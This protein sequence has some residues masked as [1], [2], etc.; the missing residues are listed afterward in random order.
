MNQFTVL[1]LLSVIGA[2]ALF[3]ALALFLFAITGTLEQIGGEE[4]GYGLQAS[5]LSKIRVGVRAIEVET[6]LIPTQV[7]LLNTTLTSVRD[8]LIVVDNN[9]AGVIA[10]VSKQEVA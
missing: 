4:R 1:L 3:I 8:G 10:A 2:S 5:Y 6:G 7:T 9:L